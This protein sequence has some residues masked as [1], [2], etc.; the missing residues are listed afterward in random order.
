[1]LVS[2]NRLRRV[3][4]DEVHLIYFWKEFRDVLDSLK[5]LRAKPFQLVLLSAT[6]PPLL[7]DNILQSIGTNR[8]TCNIY[9]EETTKKNLIYNVNKYSNSSD[10]L[11]LLTSF[12]RSFNFKY[13]R[14][15]IFCL[16]KV[17]VEE[18]KEYLKDC[19]PGLHVGCYYSG[20]QM[21]EIE[22]KQALEKWISIQPSVMI[23]TKAL[24]HGLDYAEI[25]FTIHIGM[26]DNLS[27]YQQETGRIGRRGQT[28][29]CVVLFSDNGQSV[30]SNVEEFVKGKKCR[31]E[32]LQTYLDGPG[33]YVCKEKGY[34]MCDICRIPD[35]PDDINFDDEF[36]DE[37]LALID[38][39]GT[40]IIIRFN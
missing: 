1:M 5:S 8:L 30:D 20:D 16:S 36:N 19:F 21:G 18:L 24:G 14:G 33:T 38:M 32:V 4:F 35:L 10:K 23:C 39:E 37:D 40:L 3:V 34:E 26:P 6:V 9:R 31:R 11:A 27:E 28:S 22:K 2:A 7:V 12:I 15:M 17:E 25:D 13:R 29:E